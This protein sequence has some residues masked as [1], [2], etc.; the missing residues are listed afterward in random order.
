MT[1]IFNLNKNKKYKKIKGEYSL[2]YH[3]NYGVYTE[4]FGNIDDCKTMKKIWIYPDNINSFYENGKDILPNNGQIQ[5]YDVKETE[6]FKIEN[7][8]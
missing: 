5:F 6:V 1:F 8:L 2:Y 7:K 4:S 3:P